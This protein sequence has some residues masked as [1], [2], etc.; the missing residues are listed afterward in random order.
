MVHEK[1]QLLGL[2]AFILIAGSLAAAR[3]Q[4]ASAT[5]EQQVPVTFTGGFETDRRDGGRPVVLIAAALAVKPE[6]F[7]EA[8]SGVTPARG[9]APEAGQVQ[10]NKQALMKVLGPLGVTNDRLDEVSNF[11]RY[12]PQEGE[13]WKHR[14]AMAYAKV[15]DGVI[16]ALVIAD[17]GYG[18]SSTPKVSVDGMP[19]ASLVATVAFGTDLQK[20]GSVASLALKEPATQPGK[21][22]PGE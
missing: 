17:A 5:K 4:T 9:G 6:V 7:R 11:Y 14:P 16:T 20:N 19:G 13:L 21:V 18:Y 2:L 10:R 3:A 15:K 12:R 22:K 8:F 1:W